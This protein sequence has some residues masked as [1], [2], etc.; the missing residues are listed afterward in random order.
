MGYIS[1]MS[2]EA[3][4][5]CLQLCWSKPVAQRKK[6]MLAVSVGQPAFVCVLGVGEGK[7][8]GDRGHT[9]LKGET[10][11]TCFPVCTCALV[12]RSEV[13]L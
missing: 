8:G 13:S 5:D 6:Y 9:L 2:S 4:Q 10:R 3:R 11:S 1:D 7:A 12:G